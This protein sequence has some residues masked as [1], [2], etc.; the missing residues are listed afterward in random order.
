MSKKDY[1][2]REHIKI[3]FIDVYGKVDITS[4]QVAR[5]GL[6]NAVNE[7]L[8]YLQCGVKNMV[9]AI[10]KVEILDVKYISP[11]V[12]MIITNTKML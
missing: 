12:A 4:E 9:G 8:N 3:M 10:F 7:K 6:E 2:A 1:N 5:V 11:T